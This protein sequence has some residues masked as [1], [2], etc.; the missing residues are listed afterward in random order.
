MA[1]RNC[2]RLLVNIL[3]I[4]EIMHISIAMPSEYDLRHQDAEKLSQLYQNPGFFGGD[5]RGGMNIP[6][7]PSD[8]FPLMTIK[9]TDRYKY[10]PHGILFY[11]FSSEN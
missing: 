11:E 8:E 5:M 10:W 3:I 1:M 6:E 4:L 9:E 2:E 7:S